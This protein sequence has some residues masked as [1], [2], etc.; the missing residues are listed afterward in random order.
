MAPRRPPRVPLL[1]FAALA[2]P[3]V[4][5]TLS[6]CKSSDTGVLGCNATCGT[7][8]GFTS[9]DAP[10]PSTSE[11]STSGVTTS[12]STSAST[13]ASSTGSSSTGT[14]DASTTDAS[15]T[16]ASTTDA[17]TTDAS[18]TGGSTGP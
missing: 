3:V 14:T 6:G 16:D 4:V 13:G 15:T 11:A 5:T 9:T 12:A 17:S 8:S 7:T 10:P 2:A 1:S 18:T